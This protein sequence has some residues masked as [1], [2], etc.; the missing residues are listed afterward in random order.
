MSGLYQFI[1]ESQQTATNENK[2]QLPAIIPLPIIY[3]YMYRKYLQ[4]KN[5]VGNSWS[6][7]V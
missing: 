5:P 4:G 6:N 3:I 1:G 7:D 2:L